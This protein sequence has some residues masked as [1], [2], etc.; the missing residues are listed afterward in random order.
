MSWIIRKEKEER[1]QKLVH[2]AAEM[3]KAAHRDG[4]GGLSPE[5]TAKWETLH[6]DADK[7]AEE[8]RQIVRQEQAE[9]SLI[10]LVGREEVAQAKPEARNADGNKAF[11]KYL[12]YG[13]MALSVEER[14]A[15]ATAAHRPGDVE[16]RIMQSD[17][18]S[19]GAEFAPQDFLAKFVEVQTRID[20]VREAG[21]EV[22]P[23]SHG[24]SWPYPKIDD[25][26]NTGERIADQDTAVTDNN[27]DPVT[28]ELVLGAYQYSSKMVKLSRAMVQDSAY[29]LVALAPMLRRRI[30]KIRNVD[31]TTGN[32]STAPQGCVTGSV[33]GAD[34]A[35]ATAISRADFLD[36][37]H[38]LGRQ[39]RDGA[40][41]MFTDLTLKAAKKLV[42]EN[43][44]PLWYPGNVAGGNPSTFEGYSYVINNDMAEIG[45]SAKSVLFANWAEAYVIRDVLGV[46][47]FVDPFSY[48]SKLQIGYLGAVRGDAGVKNSSAIKHLLHPASS[49]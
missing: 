11:E 37:I 14:S 36:L 17:T 3:L 10:D 27:D 20:S 5:D 26:G 45:S 44:Q 1:R 19:E 7:E 38:S 24:R 40:K 8:I 33:K 41:F 21:C 46:E 13:P 23:S 2:D 18:A 49:G 12:R 28:S 6:A 29:P 48:L 32:G 15:M 31:H 43:N 16:Q 30:D 35:S 4:K 47:L 25:T 22:I 42:D 39:Y 34:A 9:K